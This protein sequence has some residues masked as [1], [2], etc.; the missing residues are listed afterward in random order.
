M[1]KILHKIQ[2]KTLAESIYIGVFVCIGLAVL[3]AGTAYTL[4]RLA[5]GSFLNKANST[6]QYKDENLC[7]FINQHSSQKPFSVDNITT[8]SNLRSEA[9]LA[10][11][12]N[13]R[14]SYDLKINNQPKDKRIYIGNEL[15]MYTNGQ[16]QKQEV[17]VKEQDDLRNQYNFNQQAATSDKVI[18]KPM[19]K[20]AC[21]DKTCFKYR[22][23]LVENPDTYYIWFDTEAFLLRQMRLER[24][25]G[26]T[27][28]AN[29]SYDIAEIKAP[30]TYVA[31]NSAGS[32]SA[33]ASGGTSAGNSG[34]APSAPS[35]SSESSTSDVNWPDL[36]N[37]PD[38][39]Q[40][41]NGVEIYE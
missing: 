38:L 12:E 37:V 40:P 5:R 23:S 7:R 11:A 13:S 25:D 33:G 34:A 28:V 19:G 21:G 35:S 6:C 10:F 39:A 26:K 17:N 32:Q 29:Y 24:V 20:E 8:A 18:Y 14:T 22:V 27:S 16:W 31:T 3:V 1:K 30:A 9:K 36:D 2:P 41:A 4:P 15:Y